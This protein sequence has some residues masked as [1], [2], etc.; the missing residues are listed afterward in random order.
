M[1]TTDPVSRKIKLKQRIAKD[2][3]EL[4]FSRKAKAEDEIELLNEINTQIE[5]C[6]EMARPISIDKIVEWINSKNIGKVRTEARSIKF[7]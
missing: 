6:E 7:A 2:L 3:F 1:S 5:V 4:T